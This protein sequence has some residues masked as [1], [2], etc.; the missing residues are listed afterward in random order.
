M[1]VWYT[2]KWSL[3]FLLSGIFLRCCRDVDGR[4]IWGIIPDFWSISGSGLILG[5]AIWVAVAKS[6]IKHD[7]PDDLER[8]EYIAVDGDENQKD[9]EFELGELSDDEIDEH[10]P[11][12]SGSSSS[13]A[14]NKEISLE[15]QVED[16]DIVSGTGAL[17]GVNGLNETERH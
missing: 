6:K 8:S 17:T 15:E 12:T 1:L 14:Q 10:G 3:H 4:L 2:Y 7:H 16:L 11:S 9:N 5:G 13:E